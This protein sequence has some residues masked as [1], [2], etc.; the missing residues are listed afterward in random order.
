MSQ[1]RFSRLHV[2]RSWYAVSD[3]FLF[4]SKNGD[5]RQKVSRVVCGLS[6]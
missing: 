6:G 3:V 4:L 2:Q 1:T 5:D